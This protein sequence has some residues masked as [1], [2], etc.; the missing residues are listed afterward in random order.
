MRGLTELIFF[1]RDIYETY[2]RIELVLKKPTNKE[3]IYNYGY[4][5]YI[6]D[7]K[8]FCLYFFENAQLIHLDVERNSI[9]THDNS[10]NN[11]YETLLQYAKFVRII[12]TIY[13]KEEKNILTKCIMIDLIKFIKITYN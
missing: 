2:Q 6:K 1:I 4:T 3:N 5:P 9:F 12:K 13:L 8:K 7:W 11:Y 10:L